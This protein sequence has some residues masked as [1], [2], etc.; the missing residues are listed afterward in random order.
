MLRMLWTLLVVAVALGVG[1]G[2]FIAARK[3]K[4]KA[5]SAQYDRSSPQRCVANGHTYRIHDTGW[6]CAACGN[7]VPRRD[8][9][10]YGPAEVG[11]V[12]RR[13]HTR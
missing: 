5:P 13:R 7:H 11:R 10:L 3:L 8:G 1:V 9:E 6:R 2:I 4:D 12:D